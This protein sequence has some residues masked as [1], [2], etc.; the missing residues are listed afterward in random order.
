MGI[1]AHIKALLINF[2]SYGWASL[3][4]LNPNF[5]QTLSTPIVKAIKGKQILEFFTEQDYNIWK[6][7][8]VNINTYK[9]KYFKGLGSSTKED[10]KDI[11]KRFKELI[12][13]YYYK[14]DKCMESILLAFDKDKNQKPIKKIKNESENGSENGSE[15]VSLLKCSD[16]RKEWLS[17]YDKNSYIDVK[18][19]KVSFQDLINKELIHFS[20]YDNL[21]SIPSVCDGLK[22]SQRK[23]LHYMFKKNII[24]VIKVAQL[25]GY[26]SAETSYHHGEV[27]LQGAIIGLAQDYV[28]SNN[29]NLLYPDGEFG[30]RY[31][32]GKDAASPRYIFT[33]LNNITQYI[34]NKLDLPLFNYL[35]DDGVSIEPEFFMP[36]IPMILVNGCSGIG[37]GYSTYIPSYNPKDVI[38]N[39]LRILEKNTKPLPMNPW[40]K[41]FNGVIEETENG[42]YVTKGKWSVVSNTKVKITE[43]PVGTGVTNYKEF[44]ESFIEN[45]S[46]KKGE[47]IVKKIVLK[48]VQ[49]L[50]TDE[51]TG[52]CFIIEFKD[53][54]TLSDLIKGNT[55]EKELK[56]TKSFSTNNMYLFNE[57]L[58][59]TKYNDAN[60][61]ILDFYDIRLKYYQKRREYLIN[62]LKAELV[63]LESKKRFIKEYI[64]GILDINKK[65]KDII[66]VLLKKRDYHMEENSY[67]Y[68]LN[69][70][71]YSMTYERIDKLEKQCTDKKTELK[72]YE[73]KTSNELWIIDLNELLSQTL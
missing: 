53:A 24:D 48:D 49:N 56:L 59:L 25:S 71:I 9:I 8:G 72:Y 13:D 1:K 3:L 67:D 73:S 69:M 35:N 22:P 26:V 21:R 62:K 19:K 10:A 7:S 57:N 27:S 55:L 45:Y 37:T 34:Y 6:E 33:K 31:L 17:N 47:K 46:V 68:L 23:I 52:I 58:I 14:D 60:S 29:I 63:V 66:Y 2:I 12:V 32:V 64:S 20:I 61:I 50:T 42:S 18:E 16:R 28:G 11:F 5:I 65:T 15:N 44:L 39:L 54:N 38:I 70:P 40:F 30:S 41:G 51:N 43:I 36:I 4:K